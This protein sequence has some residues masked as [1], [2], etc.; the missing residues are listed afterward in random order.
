MRLLD[1]HLYNADLKKAVGSIDLDYLKGKSFFITGGLGLIASTI[2]DTLIT[3]GRTGK[4]YIGARNKA[5][6][7][8]RFGN[9]EKVCFVSYDALKPLKLDVVPDYIIHGAGLASPELYT[10]MPVETV[11]S[12]IDGIHELL[13]FAKDKPVERVLYISSSEV[14]GKKSTEEPVVEGKFG[15]VDIDSI[16]SSYAVAK[17]ASEMVCK[18]YAVEYKVDAVIVRPGHIFGPSA[19]K[20]DKRISSDFAFRA[21]L[22]EK[23]E[24]KSS[25]LQKRSYCYSIDCAIQILTVLLKGE[26]GQAYNIGHDEITTIKE[27]AEICAKAGNVELSVAHPT[28]TELK[29]FNPMNNSALDNTKVK[30]LGYKNVFS[31]KD[32][33]TH[34]IDILKE[35]MDE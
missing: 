31:V 13:H 35:M 16:R 11:L 17:R 2:V 25:G 8:K 9:L 18:A 27:M 3:Y 32:G 34:T 22:G 33:I 6:F 23:L 7:E 14:Y 19:K 26:S 24:M 4:I 5:Q 10:S 15:V 1:S 20:E 30:K 29:V 21:A 12:N 28:E